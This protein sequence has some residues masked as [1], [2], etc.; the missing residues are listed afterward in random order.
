MIDIEYIYVNMSDDVISNIILN[1]TF[2]ICPNASIE[3]WSIESQS[4]KVRGTF[5]NGFFSTEVSPSQGLETCGIYLVLPSMRTENLRFFQCGTSKF[6]I[7][8]ICGMHC[9]NIV[10]M[11][12]HEF[13]S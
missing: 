13:T 7:Y 12:S 5:T 1:V 9:G 2:L 3:V 6:F 8:H 10:L 11:L 4:L